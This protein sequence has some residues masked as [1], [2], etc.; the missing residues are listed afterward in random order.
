MNPNRRPTRP[1]E[2]VD[3]EGFLDRGNRYGRNGSYEQAIADYN[4]AIELDP[5]LAEAYYNRGFSFYELGSYEE[6]IADLSRAIELNPE[7]DRYYAQRA[8]VYLFSD[9]MDLAQAD[10]EMCDELRNRD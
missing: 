10:E 3:A 1:P 9:R 2:P 8:V 7:D 6:A 5:G 4:K